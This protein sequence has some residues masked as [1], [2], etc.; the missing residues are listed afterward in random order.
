MEEVIIVLR[1]LPGLPLEEMVKKELK[2]SVRG[3]EEG[4]HIDTHME[5]VNPERDMSVI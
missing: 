4:G 3:D 5:H 2:S 1:E